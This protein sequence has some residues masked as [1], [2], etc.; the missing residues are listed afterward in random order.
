M[1]SAAHAHSHAPGHDHDACISE[2]LSKAEAHCADTGA[3][4]TPIRRQVLELVWQSHKPVGAY[5]LLAQLGKDGQKI[6][7]PTVYR[8]L[9]FLIEQGLVHRVESLNA[10]IGCAEPGHALQQEIFICRSCGTAQ[11][12]NDPELGHRIHQ[13]AKAL[14]FKVERQTIEVVG[15]CRS[16]AA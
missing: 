11:E 2:A 7:P 9:D 3:K 15:L 6:A 8:A 4:L 13:D 1:I 10:F 5:D 14:G 16:C 12:I